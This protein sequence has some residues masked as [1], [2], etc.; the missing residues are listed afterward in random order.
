[1][2][3]GS[4][5][6]N[7]PVILGDA[8]GAVMAWDRGTAHQEIHNHQTEARITLGFEAI[9]QAVASTLKDLPGVGLTP[10]DQED[11]QAAGAEVL[12]EVVK[13]EPDRGRI[14]RLVSALR[15]YISPVATGLSQGAGEGAQEW[16]KTA[17]EQLGTP[18]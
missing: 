7:G 10:E 12:V 17:I 6:Y 2:L 9:A 5:V 8:N 16:A 1:M 3:G 13:P 11:A 18:F 4:A 15:G 14:R